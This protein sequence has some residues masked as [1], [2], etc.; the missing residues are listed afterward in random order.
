[1][2]GN[3]A[4]GSTQQS[5][6]IGEASIT[7]PSY[8]QNPPSHFRSTTLDFAS[9]IMGNDKKKLKQDF[10]IQV[11]NLRTLGQTHS[12]NDTSFDEASILD[13]AP[14][15]SGRGISISPPKDRTK[16][17]NNVIKPFKGESEADRRR[18]TEILDFIVR[19]RH[20]LSAR[21]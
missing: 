17:V 12:D 6:W 21:K 19:K 14:Q 2:L 18:A 1:M 20:E 4:F 11:H 15:M 10:N 9:P 8:A 16:V 13:A 5:P 3:S 7:D